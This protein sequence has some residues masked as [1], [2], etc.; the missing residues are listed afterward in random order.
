[1]ENDGGEASARAGGW[2]GQFWAAWY[3]QVTL[4]CL[5]GRDLREVGQAEISGGM[6]HLAEGAAKA[7]A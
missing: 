4:R 5:E 7:G 1:M 3:R 6:V 2:K